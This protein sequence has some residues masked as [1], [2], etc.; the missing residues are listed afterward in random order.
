MHPRIPTFP[1]AVAAKA[2]AVAAAV[3]LLLSGTPLAGALA[4]DTVPSYYHAAGSRLESLVSADKAFTI[5]AEDICLTEEASGVTLAEGP[6]PEGTSVPLLQIGKGARLS[7]DVDCPA[8]GGYILTLSYI[9][10]EESTEDVSFSLKI[11]GEYPFSD[12]REITL[13]SVWADDSQDYKLDRFN[14]EVYPLPVHT[15]AW[16]SKA[17]NSSVYHLD[18]PL[19]FPLKEGV[20]RIDLEFGTVPCRI[21]GIS[22]GGYAAPEPYASYAAGAASKESGVTAETE[23]ILLEGEK[24]TSKSHSYIRG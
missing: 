24:Y 9:V 4:P 1:A 10:T 7:F 5:P 3:S 22:F 21:S 17:L 15:P 14:N 23:P 16:Q 6:G 13:P 12:S 8:A 19:V 20:N 2:A 11:G 18:I